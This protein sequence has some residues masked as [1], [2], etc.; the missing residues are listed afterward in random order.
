MSTQQESRSVLVIMGSVSDWPQI[1]HA[2]D[3]MKELGISYYV[4]VTSAHRTPERMFKTAQEARSR[5]FKVIIAAAGG[6]AHLPGMVASETSLPVI[7]CPMKTSS[8]YGDQASTLSIQQ[9]PKGIPVAT[10]AL[11]DAGAYNAGL[12]AARILGVGDPDIAARVDRFVD[13]LR[14]GVPQT[15]DI[16]FDSGD[17]YPIPWR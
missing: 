9:M 4:R 1:K 5:G 10:M 12:Y 15:P 14:M 3:A 6:A 13:E 16:N 2:C 17:A 11:G 8:V 7:G